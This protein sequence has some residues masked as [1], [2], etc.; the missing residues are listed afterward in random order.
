MLGTGPEREP[1]QRS[2]AGER[3]FSPAIINSEVGTFNKVH[4]TKPTEF[5]GGV[6]SAGPITILGG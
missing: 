5:M 1:W 3:V 4:D 6:T 2:Y